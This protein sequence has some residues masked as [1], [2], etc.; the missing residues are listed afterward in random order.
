MPRRHPPEALSPR[1]LARLRASPGSYVPTEL[2][3]EAVAPAP[4]RPTPGRRRPQIVSE[5]PVGPAR[6]TR[7]ISPG[8]GALGDVEAR[9][10]RH[11]RARHPG[12]GS[13]CPPRSSE[14][15]GSRAGRPCWASSSSCSSQRPCSG[16]GWPGRSPP[17]VARSSHRAAGSGWA[18]R[19]DGGRGPRRRE[20]LG[21]QRV[22]RSGSHGIG[23]NNRASTIGAGS[24]AGG[25][26]RGAR[27]RPGQAP[28]RAPAPGGVAGH[29]CRRGSGRGGHA[30]LTCR[31]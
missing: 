12:S 2:D 5:P 25:G 3:L 29:R 21:G 19:G 14:R 13:G 31:R 30:R 9:G 24:S 18:E 22:V 1:A 26:G 17:V 23:G 6:T 20:R 8:R 16:C 15:G 4:G 11:V 27:G 10:G 7:P 28:R